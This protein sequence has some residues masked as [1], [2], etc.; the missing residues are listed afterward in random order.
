M[1]KLIDSFTV[2]KIL[3][4]E[5][6]HNIFSSPIFRKKRNRYA[7]LALFAAAYIAYYILNMSQLNQMFVTKDQL[8]NALEMNLFSS[9]SNVIIIIAGFIYLIVTI[10][11]SLTKKMQYQLKIL[12]FE[13]DSVVM[14]SILF[15][16]L[17]SYFSFLIIFAIIIP[18]LK[19]FYFSNTLNLFIFVYCQILFFASIT[20]YHFVFH[21]LSQRIRLTK[22]NLNIILLVAFLFFYFFVFRFQIDQ[23]FMQSGLAVHIPLVGSLILCLLV[24]I[25]L[26]GY[27]IYVLKPDDDDV[28]LSHDFFLWKRIKQMNYFMVIV[29]G[30]IRNKLT[31]SLIGIVCLIAIL[32]YVDTKDM[33]ITLTTLL[34]VYPIVSFSAIRYFSTTTS[35]RTLNPLFRLDA[36]L[37][38]MTTT[39]LNIILHLPLIIIVLFLPID[40]IQI[41]HYGLILFESALIMSIIF[42]KHKSSVNE[43]AASVL[44]IVLAI[45][46]FLISD[47]ILLFGIIFIVLI[48]IKY[49]L[50]ERSTYIE[51]V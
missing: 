15:K 14:G 50:L 49:Y 24:I 46:L 3:L 6:F 4:N 11:F 2:S 33:T 20:C 13:K 39:I 1:K 19:L 8:T 37:E 17:L 7:V 43:F 47:N 18:M 23:K 16:L 9:L 5:I 27:G 22:F 45:G 35:Y 40:E 32:S 21:T 10:S 34:Y 26:V 42:P 30:F 44:C 28:Y 31:L 48:G 29:L 25:G 12:P 41:M 38:T 51:A 36:A